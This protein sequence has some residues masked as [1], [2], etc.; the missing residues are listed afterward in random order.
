MG[1]E[2]YLFF[3]KIKDYIRHWAQYIWNTKSRWDVQMYPLYYCRIIN[4][5]RLGWRGIT[6]GL[7]TGLGWDDGG[8][9]AFSSTIF[10]KNIVHQQ[11]FIKTKM[12]KSNLYFVQ[13]FL[14]PLRKVT[15][16]DKKKNI[17]LILKN[18][19]MK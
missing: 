4:R 14:V 3:V 10:T 18:S 13:H 8:F 1:K 17:L 5:I 6:A 9:V 11:G 15:W 2:A 19:K 7:S 12:F 16:L